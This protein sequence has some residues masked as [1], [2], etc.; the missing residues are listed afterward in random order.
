MTSDLVMTLTKIL[1]MYV[2]SW[3]QA[4]E[5]RKLQEE[6]QASLYRYKSQVHG[7][8]RS[9]EEKLETEFQENFPQFTQVNILMASYY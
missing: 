2:L 3:Q 9:E 6:E 7:D 1:E 8:E 4:E 5:K